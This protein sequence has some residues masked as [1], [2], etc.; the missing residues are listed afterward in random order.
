MERPRWQVPNPQKVP[1]HTLTSSEPISSGLALEA[2]VLDVNFSADG[3]S[4]SLQ[5]QAKEEI[6]LRMRGEKNVVVKHFLHQRFG[7]LAFGQN[8]VLRRE[9]NIRLCD[10]RMASIN[11]TN[12]I[13]PTEYFVV[14]LDDVKN[15]YDSLF[16]DT[17]FSHGLGELDCPA[18]E[19]TESLG[20]PSQINAFGKIVAIGEKK[21]KGGNNYVKITIKDRRSNFKMKLVLWDAQVKFKYFACNLGEDF[22]N[23]FLLCDNFCVMS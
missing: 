10:I 8:C 12:S 21:W 16:L 6:L 14:L 4:C 11:K 13:L 2:E 18:G 1:F 3:Q 23:L 7:R 19:E 9:R 22:L 17:F 20:K 15:E 5:L